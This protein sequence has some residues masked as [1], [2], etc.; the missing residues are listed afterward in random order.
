MN[1]RI[2]LLGRFFWI[3]RLCLKVK[4][5]NPQEGKLKLQAHL[6]LKN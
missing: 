6:S 1:Y 3:P 4:G 2:L 5:K